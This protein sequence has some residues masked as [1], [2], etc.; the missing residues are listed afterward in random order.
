MTTTIYGTWC[1]LVNGTS[2]SPESDVLA[3]ISGGDA[4]WRERLEQSGALEQIGREFR[5]AIDDALPDGVSLCGREF[6]GPAYAQGSD[7]EGYPLTDD[8][9]LDFA[10]I[11]EGVDLAPI[12]ERNDPDING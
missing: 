2:D 9:R 5:Q 10:A 3:Y 1:S 11:I 7:F 12:V 8:G 6:L 4:D